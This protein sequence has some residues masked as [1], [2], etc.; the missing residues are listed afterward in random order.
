VGSCRGFIL[1][2]YRVNLYLWNPITAP[3]RKIPP[4]LSISKFINWFYKFFNGFGY[5][6]S[7]DHYLII[8]SSCD[9]SNYD[10]SSDVESSD[11][12]SNSDIETFVELFSFN[13]N[14]W[15]QLEGPTLPYKTS[16]LYYDHKV[17]LLFNGAFHWI[18]Y[19]CD[20]LVDLI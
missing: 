1:L 20:R 9:K 19:R 14:K 13:D 11:N 2:N 17:G 7:T 4:H 5:D 8:V 18:A 16:D 15:K 6:P 10:E 3:F 12:E